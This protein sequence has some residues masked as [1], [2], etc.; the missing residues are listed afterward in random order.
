MLKHKD[1]RF[2]HT[3]PV[4]LWGS[5]MLPKVFFLKRREFL[6]NG[7]MDPSSSRTCRRTKSWGKCTNNLKMDFWGMITSLPCLDKNFS[8][9][10]SRKTAWKSKHL[11]ACLPSTKTILK[12]PHTFPKGATLNLR[13]MVESHLLGWDLLRSLGHIIWRSDVIG[14]VEVN[15]LVSYRVVEARLL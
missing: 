14:H 7:S 9:R 5:N 13:W 11:K 10:V 3:A 12:W 1:G 2:V 8:R 6:K 4:F 15:V